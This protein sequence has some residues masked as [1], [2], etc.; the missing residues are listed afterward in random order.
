[1]NDEI[2]IIDQTYKY[3]VDE[4]VKGGIGYV[5]LMTLKELSRRPPASERLP[6]SLERKYPYRNQLAAKTIN[7]RESMHSFAK[8]C[9]LWCELNDTGIVPL[10]KTIK[11]GDEV[12][13]LMPRCAGNLRT[14]M[15]SNS[16]TP[17]ELLKALNPVIVSLSKV[18]A[19]CGLV[20]QAVKPENVLYCYHNQ[21]LVL[22]LS[23]WGIA[24]VQAS[25]LPYA[26]SERIRVLGDFRMHP[27]MAPER[28][29]NYISDLR[30]DIFSLGVIFFEI[31]TGCLP[32]KDEKRITPQIASGEYYDNIEVMLRGIADD[33]VIKLLIWMLHPEADKRLQDYGDILALIE[34]V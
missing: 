5:R 30:A 21:N 34:C 19:E 8:A 13:A 4:I 7:D 31:L 14:L 26:K 29:L 20:H 18:Y 27:Y 16:H 25:L 11:I 9:E 10:L 6:E 17:R 33:K 23:D 2:I 24:D 22:E 12:L 32:Y 1:M 15:Q 3:E 28:F